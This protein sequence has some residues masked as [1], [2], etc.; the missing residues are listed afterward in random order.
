MGKTSDRLLRGLITLTHETLGL[1]PNQISAA[2]FV[3]GVIAAL[4]VALGFLVYGLVTMALGQVIDGLDGGVARRY[5]LQ[6]KKGRLLELVYDR[7]S[8]LLMFLALVYAGLVSQSIAILA[9]VAILLVTA[10]EPW[11][12]F[13]PGF[14]RFMIYF[15]YLASTIFQVRGFEAAMHVIFFANL[16]GFAVGTIIADYQ[17]QREID[18]QAIVRRAAEQAMGVP[19]LPVDS[20]SFLSRLFS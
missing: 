15:G 20:P 12:H 19:E 10:V 7:L 11:S 8:E 17:L 18:H 4:L 9:F 13:D 14:K 3:A 2:G 1:T 16:A 5:H 6:S